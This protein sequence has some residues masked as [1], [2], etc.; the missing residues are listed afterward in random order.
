MDTNKL[1]YFSALAQTENVRK[2]SELLH[3][4]PSALSKTLQ[5]L[6][7]ELDLKL[8]VP[9][10]RGL[11]LTPAGR[12]LAR[13]AT[14][15]IRQ[16]DTLKES[17]QSERNVQRQHPLRIASFE[18]FSTY[19]LHALDLVNWGEQGLVLHEL[20]PGELEQAVATRQVDLGITYLP[21]P[22][23]HLEHIKVCRIEMGVFKR[24]G[25]FRDE[26]QQNLP[27]VVPVFP[28]HGVP[29]RA[30]GL[31]GWPEDAYDRKVRFEVT[32]MES[33]LELCRQGR[34][35]GYFP[36][37]IVHEHNRK[38]QPA[39]YL[40]RHPSPFP[41][42]KCYSDVYLVKPK[43]VA[44]DQAFRTIARMLRLACR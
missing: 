34:C 10:G 25:S 32:L 24:R 18:V 27:F 26:P 29:S 12:R 37:F 20:L 13:E 35:A 14:E 22:F 19:F 23:K 17:L 42:R 4:T 7:S 9:L 31:D 36:C 44:E 38:Y 43:D 30:R 2:A 33:A 8:T 39:Y 28:L 40:D 16:L 1:R 5:S 11:T 41:G 15:L 21:I 3:I 6:E